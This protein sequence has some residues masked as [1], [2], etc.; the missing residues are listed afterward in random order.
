MNDPV[1]R[2]FGNLIKI[3]S[4]QP[5]RLSYST[6]KYLV[7]DRVYEEQVKRHNKPDGSNFPL[8]ALIVDHSYMMVSAELDRIW[9]FIT[10]TDCKTGEQYADRV[11]MTH[12]EQKISNL[13]IV[14]N[15]QQ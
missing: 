1:I 5:N 15:N 13:N 12:L 6:R 14:T 3:V 4:V 7:S 10:A 2:I 9:Y 11:L 8:E